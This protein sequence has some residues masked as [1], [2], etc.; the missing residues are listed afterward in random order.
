MRQYRHFDNVLLVVFFSHPRYDVNLDYYERTYAE[1]FPNMVFVGPASRE[2]AGFNH[3]YDV[4]VDSYGSAENLTNPEFYQMAG[5]MAHH[6]LFTVMKDHPCYHGYLWAP[7]DTLLN[8]PRLQ[9]FDQNRF[10][11]HSPFGEYVPNSALESDQDPDLHAPP[12]R[13]SPDPA[14]NLTEDWKG[15]GP[16]W[17]DPH[18]G[19]PACLPAFRKAPSSQHR[20]LAS[21]FENGTERFLGGSSDTL[22]V[23]GIHREA[24][25]ETLALF[26]ETECFMEIALPTTVHL[27][28]PPSERI[29]FVDH[30]WI[31]QP[32]FNATF[33]RMKWEEGFEVDTFH[34][35]HWGDAAE[36]E[37]WRAHPEN[38]EDVRELLQESARRQ[39]VRLPVA[40]SQVTGRSPTASSLLPVDQRQA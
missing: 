25:L 29:L 23:P 5:R 39:G 33:V 15:W 35:F 31:W 8:V 21:F 19:L 24:F 3:S 20:R 36:G 6:M 40:T 7:F 34:T 17:C 28:V 9:Q 32:P 13:I 12:A 26:L 14:L 27:V 4:I 16:D 2:D 18:V 30:W 38:I 10:W 1:Y 11:Y 22:Y 37:S